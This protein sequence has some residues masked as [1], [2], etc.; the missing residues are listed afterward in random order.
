MPSYVYVHGLNS[1]SSSRSGRELEKVIGAP[2]YCPQN[3]YSLPFWDCLNR[4]ADDIRD[5]TLPSDGQICLLGTSLGGFYASQLRLP[6]IGQL[7]I[8]NPVIFPATQL[9]RFIGENTRFTDGVKWQFSESA[10]LSYAA[11]PDPRE[12]NNSFLRNLEK[13]D[14]Q[15][16]QAGG[17]APRRDVVLGIHDELLD[18][19]LADL[20]WRDH[21]P[22]LHIDAGHH[23][24]RF[25]HVLTLLE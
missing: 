4:L 1:G 6:N 23:I 17:K 8:W 18:Y 5:N 9:A 10:C 16:W 19:R 12:W 25:D 24:E 20:Y 7:V 11:A 21:A 14:A 22:V 13:K 3:D 15:S 2:V